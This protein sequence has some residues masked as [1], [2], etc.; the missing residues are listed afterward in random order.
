MVGLEVPP[1]PFVIPFVPDLLGLNCHTAIRSQGHTLLPS[2]R[3]TVLPSYRPT[4]LPS[5]RPTVIPSYR[6]TVITPYR[7]N[8]VPAY[9]PPVISSYRPTVISLGRRSSSPIHFPNFLSLFLSRPKIGAGRILAETDVDSER[10]RRKR[11]LWL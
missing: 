5:Y 1:L 11:R 7:H 10:F 9:R 8:A 6:H 3:P 2:Y 4:V